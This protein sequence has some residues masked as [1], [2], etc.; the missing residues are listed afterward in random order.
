MDLKRNGNYSL[1]FQKLEKLSTNSIDL[2]SVSTYI[3]SQNLIVEILL[4]RGK[5]NEAQEILSKLL[6][7]QTKPKST[8]TTTQKTKSFQY[9]YTIYQQA[10]LKCQLAEFDE[11]FNLFSNAL[12]IVSEKDIYLEAKIQSSIGSLFWDRGKYKQAFEY[13][14]HA[15]SLFERLFLSNLPNNTNTTDNNNNN[16]IDEKKKTKPLNLIIEHLKIDDSNA[17]LVI[18]YCRCLTLNA[19]TKLKLGKLNQGLKLAQKALSFLRKALLTERHPSYA[20]VCSLIGMAM[21]KLS[22]YDQAIKILE[23][24]K[25]IQEETIGESPQYSI[26][27]RLYGSVLDYQGDY[28]VSFY[29]FQPNKHNTN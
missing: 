17:L 5:H 4:E 23:L 19:A 18:D 6:I 27:L 24:A 2:N 13:Q 8:S 16:N 3:S 26:I 29:S 25:S 7:T 1:N 20:F 9:A 14:T 21:E 10:I 28:K 12:E 11:S 15:R 22:L